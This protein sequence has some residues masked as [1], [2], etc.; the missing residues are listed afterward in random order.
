MIVVKKLPDVSIPGTISWTDFL[1]KPHGTVVMPI[2]QKSVRL[3]MI[4]G[5]PFRVSSDMEPCDTSWQ[6]S[7][8]ILT[9]EDMHIIFVPK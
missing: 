7:R 1:L 2:G 5:K 3:V 9:P 6:C 8:F 4:A